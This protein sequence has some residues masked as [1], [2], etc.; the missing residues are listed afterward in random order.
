MRVGVIVPVHGWA[1]YLAEALDSVRAEGP[2]EV[3]V[4]DDGSPEPS[5]LA[6]VRRPARGG[7]AAARQTGLEAL[8]RCDVVALCDADDA[9]RP[10][11]LSAALGGLREADVAVG[12]AEV[13]GDGAEVPLQ[14]R[15]LGGH[16]VAG[17]HLRDKVTRRFGT[18]ILRENARC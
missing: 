12:G 16:V 13:V 5:P 15:Q 18:F 17:R 3:V 7:P 2:D 14:R 1:P 10:G 9:W 8:E 6:T 4:V 11:F